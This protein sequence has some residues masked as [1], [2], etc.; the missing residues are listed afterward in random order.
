MGTIMRRATRLTA[1]CATFIIGLL[2]TSGCGGGSKTL[3][4]PWETGDRTI[5]SLLDLSDAIE[6]ADIY[7]SERLRLTLESIDSA[8]S[9][10]SG[11]GVMSAAAAFARSRLQEFASDPHETHAIDSAALAL[12]PRNKASYLR[13][14]LLLHMAVG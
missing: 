1:I 2:I 5:D 12:L 8:A 13:A 4:M 14:R 10:K 9:L 7:D 11:D 3:R 6:I